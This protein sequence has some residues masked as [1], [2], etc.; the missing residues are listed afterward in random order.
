MIRITLAAVGA[1]LLLAAAPVLAQTPAPMTTTASGAMNC[2]QQM[3]KAG[4]MMSSMTPS[5][6]KKAAME[7]A[8][9][10][11]DSMAKG[12]EAGCMMHMHKAMDVMQ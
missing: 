10:A 5:P 3:A 4:P 8:D 11:K 1:T 12:D 9:M 6:K 7:E 2:K